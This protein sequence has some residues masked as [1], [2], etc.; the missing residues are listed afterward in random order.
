MPSTKQMQQS[1]DLCESQLEQRDYASVIRVLVHKADW[2]QLC[3]ARIPSAS[4]SSDRCR[5][6]K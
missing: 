2:P 1:H 4:Q 5:G 6:V 3:A